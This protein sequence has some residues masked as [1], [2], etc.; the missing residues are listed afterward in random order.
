MLNKA[1]RQKPGWDTAR[2]LVTAVSAPTCTVTVRGVS[3]SGVSYIVQPV[4]DDIVH[5]QFIGNQVLVI[6]PIAG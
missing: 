1:N 2:G 3:L 6:G 5:V 4:V